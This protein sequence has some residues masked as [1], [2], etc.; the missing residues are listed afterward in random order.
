[1]PE[2]TISQDE[3]DVRPTWRDYAWIAVAL[4]AAAGMISAVADSGLLVG[5]LLV[6]AGFWIVAGAYR[7]TVWGCPFSHAP[8]AEEQCPRHDTHGDV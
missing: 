5:A 1:M 4:V 7:R 3:V 6:L 2:N 8:G